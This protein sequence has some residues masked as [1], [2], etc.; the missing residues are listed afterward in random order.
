MPPETY[1]IEVSKAGYDTTTSDVRN[2]LLSSKY[3]L[4]KFHSDSSGS[5]T[6]TA[7]GTAGSISFTH[8]LGY[9]PMFI[10][11]VSY[12]GLDSYQ[13]IVPKGVS[14]QPEIVNAFATSS[15][16]KCRADMIPYGYDLTYYFRVITFKDR[17]S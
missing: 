3:P 16:V 4:L 10:A 13:R 9:V 1:G 6:I 2:I 7:G 8:S 11:Y 14:G 17:I 5:F 12:P 15:I